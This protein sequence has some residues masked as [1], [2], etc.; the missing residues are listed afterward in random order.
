ASTDVLGLAEIVKAIQKIQEGKVAFRPGELVLVVHPKQYADL[1]QNTSLQKAMEFGGPEAIREGRIPELLG[2]RVLVST[3]VRTGTGSGSPPITTYHAVLFK[4]RAVGFATTRD[5]L[6]ETFR[7]VDKRQ[8][9]I[10]GSLRSA[11]KV[12]VPE[13]CCKIYTA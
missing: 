3:Q 13:A 6:I 4:A 1:L 7:A 10:T 12:L 2:C 11:A 9:E 8:L 5:L